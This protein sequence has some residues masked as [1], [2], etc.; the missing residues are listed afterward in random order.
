MVNLELYYHWL[1]LYGVDNFLKD[2]TEAQVCVPHMVPQVS[3]EMFLLFR[4]G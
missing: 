1:V 3:Q 2:V 4:E